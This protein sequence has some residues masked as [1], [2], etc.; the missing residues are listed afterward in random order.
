M[1]EW[2]RPD[3]PLIS[4]CRL[5]NIVQIQMSFNFPRVCFVREYIVK[6]WHHLA[7]ARCDKRGQKREKKLNEETKKKIRE[8]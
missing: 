4:C 2:T 7:V 3:T 8:R 6:V 1:I 5:E